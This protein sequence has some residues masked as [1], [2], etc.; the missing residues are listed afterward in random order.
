MNWG[1]LNIL[2]LK[3]ESWGW[4]ITAKQKET[5]ENWTEGNKD[6]LEEWKITE[7]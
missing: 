1:I 5:I 3:G 6:I 4:P 2:M 7:S